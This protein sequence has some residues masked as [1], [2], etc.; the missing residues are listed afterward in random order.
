MN[1]K[2]INIIINIIIKIKNNK[3][4]K[5]KKIEIICLNNLENHNKIKKN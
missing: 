5:R 3:Y 4:S 1:M 2:A